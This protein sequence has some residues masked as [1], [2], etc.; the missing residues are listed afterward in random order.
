MATVFGCAP[1]EPQ[2]P[3]EAKWHPD[4]AMIRSESPSQSKRAGGGSIEGAHASLSE[5]SRL[6]QAQRAHGPEEEEES[7]RHHEAP[8]GLA[9]IP[10]EFSSSSGVGSNLHHPLHHPRLWSREP[11]G[12][13]AVI[14]GILALC[15]A[16]GAEGGYG[17][18]PT[19]Q[20]GMP[21]GGVNVA[22]APRGALAHESTSGKEPTGQHSGDLDHGGCPGRAM[23]HAHSD[24]NA[25]RAR[26]SCGP[27]RHAGLRRQQARRPDD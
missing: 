27:G 13:D 24:H 19:Q 11:W 17:Q 18:G 12:C 6:P 25:L 10:F 3:L 16:S 23:R 26:P 15:G 22:L 4:R 9:H 7:A 8:S 14:Q 20:C 2:L 5:G 21:P 1:L